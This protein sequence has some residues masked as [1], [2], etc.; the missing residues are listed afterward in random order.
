MSKVAAMDAKNVYIV[1]DFNNW[2]TSADPMEKFKSGDYHI[3][4]DLEPGREY[5][6]R[7]LIDEVR[8]ENDGNADKYVRSDYG[9]CDNSVVMIDALD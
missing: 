8:W 2:N 7:Y 9:G 3:E 1:G 6:F 4:L 5:Q